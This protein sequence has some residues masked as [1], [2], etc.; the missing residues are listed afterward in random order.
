MERRV[1]MLRRRARGQSRGSLGPP[2]SGLGSEAVGTVVGPR[3]GGEGRL[4]NG[5][6]EEGAD[7]A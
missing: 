6:E 5:W 1:P 7:R 4:V 3:G 2:G